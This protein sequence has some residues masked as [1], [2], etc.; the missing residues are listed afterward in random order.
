MSEEMATS[1]TEYENFYQDIIIS[2]CRDI[3]TDNTLV[4]S[5]NSDRVIWHN[6]IIYIACLLL[7]IFS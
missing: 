7:F 5:I 6:K 4:C 2:S 1:N 3:S